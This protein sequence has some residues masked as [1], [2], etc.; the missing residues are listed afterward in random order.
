MKPDRVNPCF[1]W[2]LLGLLL[3]TI[4]SI[5]Q[6]FTLESFNIDGGSATLSGGSYI[7][8]A[9]VGQPNAGLF[10]GGDFTLQAGYWPVVSEVIVPD[11]TATLLSDGTVQVCWPSSATEFSLQEATT[12]NSVDWSAS[13]L[14]QNDGEGTKCVTVSA[15]AGSRFFR[16]VR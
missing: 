3:T 16:L 12:L 5:A 7:V 8:I 14:V 6:T 4:P 9:T 10:S 15:T 13:A 1:S 11:L 2:L